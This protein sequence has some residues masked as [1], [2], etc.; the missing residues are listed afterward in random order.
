LGR[1]WTGNGSK[2]HRRR[3]WWWSSVAKYKWVWKETCRLK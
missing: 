3:W 2:R 1:P